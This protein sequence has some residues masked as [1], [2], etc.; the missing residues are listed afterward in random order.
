[1]SIWTQPSSSNFDSHFVSKFGVS[2]VDYFVK[3]YEGH[4]RLQAE[5]RADDR[6]YELMLRAMC[7]RWMKDDPT[8]QCGAFWLWSGDGLVLIDAGG[9]LGNDCRYCPP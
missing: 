1:M 5:I 7:W 2:F 8:L 4:E 3:G 6:D 9:D